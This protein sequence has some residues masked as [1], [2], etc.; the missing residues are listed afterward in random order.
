MVRHKQLN[1]V[2]NYYTPPKKN[3]AAN[4][5]REGT[6]N[7]AKHGRKQGDLFRAVGMSA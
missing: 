2:Y 7:Y 6:G 1:Y 3:I 5:R 4:Q